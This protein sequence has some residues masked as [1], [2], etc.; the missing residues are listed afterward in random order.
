MTA[1]VVIV[2]KD[3]WEELERRG[4]RR[5]EEIAARLPS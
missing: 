5:L 4:P 2:I 1:A 3:Q